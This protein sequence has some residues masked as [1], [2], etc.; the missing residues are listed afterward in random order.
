MRMVHLRMC[1]PYVIR[2]S[3]ISQRSPSLYS[4]VALC[5]VASWLP[6]ALVQLQAHYHHCGAAASEK[7][8]SAAT[9][10]RQTAQKSA[11]N[12][13]GK[14]I[15]RIDQLSSTVPRCSFLKRSNVLTN[16]GHLRHQSKLAC[17]GVADV[18]KTR[19]SKRVMPIVF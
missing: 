7:C 1:I 12:D 6:N 16:K 5:D 9:F 19:F 4:L 3:T 2:R 15:A 14:V 10:V 18:R 13:H 8:L 11:L 17:K